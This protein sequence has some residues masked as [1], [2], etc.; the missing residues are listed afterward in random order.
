MVSIIVPAYNVEKYIQKCLDSILKQ[1]YQNWETIIVDD[2]S[3]DTTGAICEQLV[4]SD[5]RFKVIHQANAGLSAARDTGIDHAKGEYLLFVDADDFIHP[6]M[7]ELLHDALVKTKSDIA[8]CSFQKIYENQEVP[9]IEIPDK[10]TPQVASGE[11]ECYYLYGAERPAETVIAWNKLYTKRLF[12]DIRYPVGKIHEDHFV[13]YQLLFAAKQVAYIDVPLYYY[14]QRE[15]SIMHARHYG[16]EHMAMLEAAENAIRFYELKQKD[17][18]TGLAVGQALG[19]A[20]MLYENYKNAQNRKL[21]KQSLDFYRRVY[22]VY[23]TYMELD[24]TERLILRTY[25]ISPGLSEQLK[26]LK[27]KLWSIK[28]GTKRMDFH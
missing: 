16:E 15:G 20:K 6:K 9:N 4:K 2:G 5:S 1:T 14:L 22:R 13:T 25:G 26:K 28:H 23:G 8:I 19:F 12:A 11:E 21:S 3:N 10:I 7:I 24:C 27:A 17:Q 18:L